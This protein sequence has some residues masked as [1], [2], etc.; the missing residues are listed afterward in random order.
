[1]YALNHEVS[2]IN[3]MLIGN[4]SRVKTLS[5][6]RTEGLRYSNLTKPHCLQSS[7]CHLKRIVRVDR[8]STS[9]EQRVTLEQFVKKHR[10]A[11][12]LQKILNEPRRH[13]RVTRLSTFLGF[14]HGSVQSVPRS[15]HWQPIHGTFNEFRVPLCEVRYF[16]SDSE[17][18]TIYILAISGYERGNTRDLCTLDSARSDVKASIIIFF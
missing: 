18:D 11:S 7:I 6:S 3:A 14:T 8:L 1:M 12:N 10:G 2:Q 15:A 9:L 17:K 5:I 13:Y 16:L 4:V